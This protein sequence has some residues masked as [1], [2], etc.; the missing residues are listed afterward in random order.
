[1]GRQ[2][3]IQRQKGVSSCISC[4]VKSDRTVNDSE[5]QAL[6]YGKQVRAALRSSVGRCQL[7]MEFCWLRQLLDTNLHHRTIPMP[8]DADPA[9]EQ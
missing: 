2:N 3:F 1:M 7:L 8:A 6:R 9:S 4:P 5:N